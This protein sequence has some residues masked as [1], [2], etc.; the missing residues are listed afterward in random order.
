MNEHLEG[1][2]VTRSLRRCCILGHRVACQGVS[3]N[4]SPGTLAQVQIYGIIGLAGRGTAPPSPLGRGVPL[5]HRPLEPRHGPSTLRLGALRTGSPAFAHISP[6]PRVS[7]SRH[8]FMASKHASA[9][10]LLPEGSTPGLAIPA[11]LCSARVTSCREASPAD[12][13]LLPAVVTAALTAM[14]TV[15]SIDV[16]RRSLRYAI[17]STSTGTVLAWG[18]A[19]IYLDRGSYMAA[20]MEFEQTCN[21]HSYST[22][23]IERQLRHVNHQ[24]GRIEANLEALFTVRELQVHLMPDRLGLRCRDLPVQ[25][26]LHDGYLGITAKLQYSQLRSRGD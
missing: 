8:I 24:A 3:A 9:P 20:I 6:H 14:P 12:A 4:P 2:L 23:V 25:A 11:R 15:V 26:Q 10:P 13:C 22:V 16:G 18:T 19:E 1:E 7:Q 21:A 5:H 17:Y